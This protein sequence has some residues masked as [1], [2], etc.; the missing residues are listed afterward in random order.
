MVRCGSSEA[1]TRIVAKIRGRLYEQPER[2]IDAMKEYRRASQI[3]DLSKAVLTK[4]I[5]AGI[6]TYVLDRLLKK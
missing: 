4:A 6:A 1:L 5:P 2:D 3:Q